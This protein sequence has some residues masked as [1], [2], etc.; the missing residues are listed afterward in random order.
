MDPTPKQILRNQE[1]I[2]NALTI[3]LDRI[4]SKDNQFKNS[5]YEQL[6]DEMRYTRYILS[7][8]L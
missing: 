5:V 4:P 6:D 2:M 8:N 3:L 1:A 7:N